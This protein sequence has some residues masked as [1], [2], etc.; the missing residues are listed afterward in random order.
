MT[1]SVGICVFGDVVGSRGGATAATAWLERLRAHLETTWPTRLAPFEFTQGDEI[2]GL[3]PIDADPLALVLDA[4]LRSHG[5][6]HGSPRM[7][8]AIAAGPVDP[9]EGPATKRTGPAFVT[10]R[11]LVGIAR[12]EG[13]GLRC[14]TGDATTD[15][16]LDGVA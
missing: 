15:E 14:A 7:R 6:P 8:W 2:Q 13:D 12:R 3:L 9:G 11:R 16:L 10:A 1:S 5:P 4:M